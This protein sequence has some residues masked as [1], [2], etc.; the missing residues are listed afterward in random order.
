MT[1]AYSHPS[2]PSSQA[3]RAEAVS[4]FAELEDGPGS[5][6]GRRPEHR[7]GLCG[8]AEGGAALV[9]VREAV[10]HQRAGARRAHELL[11]P[12]ALSDR[13]RCPPVLFLF[14]MAACT[15]ED[16]EHVFDAGLEKQQWPCFCVFL[17]CIFFSQAPCNETLEMCFQLLIF[18]NVLRLSKLLF[19]SFNSLYSFIS[20][21]KC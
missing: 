4:I 16:A 6:S 18:K 21:K 13:R 12:A 2:T 5:D 1:V 11:T 20:F 7:H 10:L 3:E 19:F 8:E 15:C 14:Y 17:S 9:C